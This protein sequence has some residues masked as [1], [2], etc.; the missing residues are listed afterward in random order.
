MET[1]HEIS[2]DTLR[3]YLPENGLHNAIQ[4][5]RPQ[6]SS[7]DEFMNERELLYKVLLDMKRD[8][9][10]MRQQLNGLMA[11]QTP[12]DPRP[13]TYDDYQTVEVLH[14]EQP[15]NIETLERDS[16]RR[17]LDKSNG[18]R[19]LAADALGISE[20]TLYRKIKD[21]GL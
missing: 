1:N 17:A 12:N 6:T 4:L 8:M 9:T 15:T 7:G 18:N 3:K 5:A 16:I 10:E 19:K 14:D 2:A 13:T 11:N 20:R 21:Y